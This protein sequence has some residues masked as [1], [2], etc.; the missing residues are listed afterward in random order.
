MRWPLLVLLALCAVAFSTPDATLPRGNER[1][2]LG[3]ARFQVDSALA[4]RGVERL[5]AG[6]D[7]ITT[8]GE[9]PEVEYVEYSFAPS[10]HG[11]GFLWKVTFGY[12]VPYDR[13][14]FD[15]ARGT[16]VTDLGPPAEEHLSDP[17]NGDLLDNLTWADARTVVH[18]GARWSEHQDEGADRMLVTWIDRQLQKRVDSQIRKQGKGKK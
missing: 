2:H 1:F 18:L 15:G 13:V 11:T 16:L 4:A 17:K 9:S 6:G 5:S 8:P 10:P 7:F 12:R 3:W 14:V